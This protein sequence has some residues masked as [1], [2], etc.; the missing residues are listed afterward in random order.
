VRGK[1]VDPKYVLAGHYLSVIYREM[2]VRGFK[3]INLR[4]SNCGEFM[5]HLARGTP[6]LYEEKSPAVVAPMDERLSKAFMN[7][8]W[9]AGRKSNADDRVDME[10]LAERFLEEHKNLIAELALTMH[11]AK[12]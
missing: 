5:E 7:V 9:A 3:P 1:V 4:V 10:R 12:K 11:E 2:A 8:I 6:Q